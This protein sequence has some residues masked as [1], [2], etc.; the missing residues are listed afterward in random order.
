M[1][2]P[3]LVN[4]R[5][6]EAAPWRRLLPGLQPVLCALFLIAGAGLERTA[7]AAASLPIYVLAYITGG[8]GS[9]FTAL[10]VLRR[11]RV[12]VNLLMLLAAGGAAWLGEWAEGGV[13]LFL[14]STSNALEY[15][16]MG[17][18]RRAIRAL[19][20][21][22]PADA[23]VRRGTIEV[24]VPADA[25]Q[26]GD[27]VIVKPAERLAAD[28]VVRV[29]I[30][31]IDQSPI[32]GESIPVDVGPGSSVFAGTIN[33]RGSLEIEV[34]RDPHDSTLAR[35]ITMVEHAQSAQ[36][37]TQRL[38]DRFG[39][40]YAVAVIA[41]AIGAYWVFTLLAQ[42]AQTALY[43]AITLLV[44]ASPCAV[45]I[46]APSAVLSAIAAAARAGVLFK[47]GAHM[48]QLALTRTVVFDKT[49]TLTVGHP[50]VTDVITE[51]GV[52]SDFLLALAGTLESRS[53]H[54]LAEAV[55]QACRARGVAFGVPD[56]FEAVTGRGIRGLVGGRL[57]RAGSEQFMRDEGI[58][59][60]D[61]FR[62]ELVALRHEGKTP[63]VVAGERTL[64]I[65]AVADTLRPHAAHALRMLRDLGIRRLVLLTGDHSD[66][67]RSI[68]A[69]LDIDEVRAG[70]LPDEKALAV[71]TY[72]GDGVVAMVG[73]GVNDAPALAT[74]DV[75][76]AMGGAGTDAAMETADVVLMG[77]DL[78][79]LPYAIDLS[80]Q[81]R[82]VM[83][84]SLT[85]ASLVIITL[86]GLAL[87]LGLRLAF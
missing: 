19:M 7:G 9:L 81:T 82:R 40:I 17:R 50:A 86:I 21:L 64:G 4:G 83:V 58:P 1:S 15:Y 32:T 26:I 79:R 41:G 29:G 66:V 53:E 72:A 14:F 25:L 10:S 55:V 87:G 71:G 37:P 20:E 67:A 27:T 46:A 16:A 11:F 22:R 68:A 69:E 8:T 43:R 70:L 39:Q 47:G 54:A 57:I 49:G 33:Q 34:T 62:A 42:P 48:E 85:F 28:G 3:R 36:A 59:L 78:R 44:V 65:V 84:Q 56:E 31:G 38:I 60:S 24:I 63:I 2:H 45:V 73:D 74:A 5:Q 51:D 80:R 77:D 52:E 61:G 23:L 75:G 12:D 30:S 76:I 13:L 18:T 35:I 6:V